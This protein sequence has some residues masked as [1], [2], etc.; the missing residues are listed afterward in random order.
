MNPT[1]MTLNEAANVLGIKPQSVRSRCKAG[2]LKGERDNSGKI[3]VWLDGS[4]PPNQRG[5][6]HP[7]QQV[8]TAGEIEALRG[9]IA[10]MT[11][12]LEIL[13]PK[14]AER[15][16]LEGERAGLREMLV[17]KDERLADRDSTI[18]KLWDHLNEERAARRQLHALLTDQRPAI[19]PVEA[20]ESPKR[21]WWHF[22]RAND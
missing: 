1:R 18:A 15:D 3:W 14:A 20:V 19:A 5:S 2:K 22:G 13:R 6:K 8:A 11:A 12:E 9:H 4:I 17:E 21:R 7:L 10:A 16:R